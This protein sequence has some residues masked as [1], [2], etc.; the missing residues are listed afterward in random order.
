MALTDPVLA[1][2]ASHTICALRCYALS[3]RTPWIGYLMWALVAAAMAVQGVAN[4]LYLRRAS[5][6]LYHR[7]S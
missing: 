3:H 2:L 7:S 5:F 1:D 4:F 6:L